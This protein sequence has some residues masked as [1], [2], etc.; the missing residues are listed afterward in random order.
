MNSRGNFVDT[1]FLLCSV[2][3]YRFEITDPIDYVRLSLRVL[4]LTCT[5]TALEGGGRRV[6][7]KKK[8][9]NHNKNGGRETEFYR[10]LLS[11][12]LSLSLT[13]LCIF[14]FCSIGKEFAN[15]FLLRWIKKKSQNTKGKKREKNS[16]RRESGMESL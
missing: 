15:F 9:K 4:I 12:S 6:G 7:K 8:K 13:F 1:Q 2:R 3:L 10:R 16:S 11:L 5:S 14:H